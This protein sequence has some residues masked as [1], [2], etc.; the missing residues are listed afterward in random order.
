MV[1]ETI[2]SNK[3]DQFYL[4]ICHGEV[5]PVGFCISP[6]LE[7]WVYLCHENNSS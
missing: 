4:V 2:D 6:F 1:N 3:T 5:R 7:L